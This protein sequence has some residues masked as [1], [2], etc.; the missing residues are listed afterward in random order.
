[1]VEE[2]FEIWLSETPQNDLILLFFCRSHTFIMNEE[3]FE[4]WL[5]ETPQNDLILL[6]IFRRGHTFTMVVTNF[7]IWLCETQLLDTLPEKAYK[8][9]GFQKSSSHFHK[10]IWLCEFT[11]DFSQNLDLVRTFVRPKKPINIGFF[12][13]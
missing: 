4:V 3:K 8:H 9:W 12:R 2:N 7:E 11:L 6:C 10:L 13:M 5:S 1:M